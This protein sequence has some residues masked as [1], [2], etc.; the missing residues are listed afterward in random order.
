L[1]GVA[2]EPVWSRVEW[3]A[4]EVGPD[5]YPVEQAGVVA[6]SVG[7]VAFEADSDGFR[8]EPDAFEV[9]LGESLVGLAAFEAGQGGRAALRD[10]FQVERLGD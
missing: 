8:V 2:A 7:L 6:G 9:D 10:D 3:D 1:S 5:D 4:P